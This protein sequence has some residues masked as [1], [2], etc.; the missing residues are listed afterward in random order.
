MDNFIV[1]KKLNH[2]NLIKTDTEGFEYEVIKG[3][4]NNINKVQLIHFEHHFD[5]MLIKNYKFSNIHKYLTENKFQKILK[6]KMFFR[7]TFEYIY[8]NTEFK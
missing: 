6:F 5:N 8:L 3:L 7:K 2:I 1:D 4:K